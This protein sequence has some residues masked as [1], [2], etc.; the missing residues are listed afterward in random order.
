LLADRF[1]FEGWRKRAVQYTLDQLAAHRSPAPFSL[2]D[3]DWNR[4]VLAAL[5]HLPDEQAR[6]EIPYRVFSVR[7]FNDS[8][9]F[10]GLKD[11]LARLARR[12][13]P[14]WR[15]LSPA[16][17]LRELGLVAN[18]NHLY[19][20]GP[21]QLVDAQG[22]AS[23]LDGFYPSVGIPAA[24]A[25]QV[26]RVSVDASRVVCVENL[27]AFYELVRRDGQD[28]AALC[29]AGN[30]APA[31]RH[32]LRCLAEELPGHVPLLVWA[33]IDYG[34]L[35]ILSQLRRQVATRCA[36]YHMD[37]ATLDAHARWA[38]PLSAG[39]ERH[40]AR[41]RRDPALGDMAPLIDHMLL[42]GIKLEQEAVSVGTRGNS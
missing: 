32:L 41:L 11:I 16:E 30:P 31:T 9:R 7:V 38:Q 33:D 18:P 22:R 2:S 40:L 4:D 34:G 23:G 19:L 24:L 10:D 3:E 8:K 12:H 35:R 20:S 6:E 28:L 5:I 26:R 25:G 42:R 15:G 13:Q 14:A 29:L 36:P 27:A 39:D 1:R 37:Q 17:T 21:W